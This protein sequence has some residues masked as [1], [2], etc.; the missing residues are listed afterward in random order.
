MTAKALVQAVEVLEAERREFESITGK[1][2]DEHSMLLA[3]KR[4]LPPA[5]RTMLQTVEVAG[6]KASKENVLKQAR[7]FRNERASGDT[8]GGDKK[9]GGLPL[10]DLHHLNGQEDG[11]EDGAETLALA[12]KGKGK[13]GFK[14]EC[15]N[16]G[17]TGHRAAD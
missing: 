6:Y 11:A 12:K 8:Q 4:M 17:K 10:S 14:G 13:G 7:E 9:T 1:Q 5:I 3:L 2:P 15:F 16:C